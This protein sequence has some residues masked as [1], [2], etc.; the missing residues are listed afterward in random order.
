[1]IYFESNHKNHYFTCIFCIRG[2]HKH[3]IY[4]Q[5]SGLLRRCKSYSKT[6]ETLILLMKSDDF[7]CLSVIWIL[8]LQYYENFTEK[9]W[10]RVIITNVL[11]MFWGAGVVLNNRTLTIFQATQVTYSAILF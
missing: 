5:S 4:L 1:M 8:I 10:S 11:D 2:N 9:I 6:S 3:C 7:V